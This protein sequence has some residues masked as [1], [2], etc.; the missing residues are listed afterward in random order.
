MSHIFD[1]EHEFTST[2]RLVGS[3]TIRLV[4]PSTLR[5]VGSSTLRLVGSSSLRLVGSSLRLVG[6][7]SVSLPPYTIIHYISI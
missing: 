5:L 7:V 3:S 6:V 4:A 1:R 2:L